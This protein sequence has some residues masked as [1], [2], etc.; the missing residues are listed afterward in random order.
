MST[1]AKRS[2]TPTATPTLVSLSVELPPF[3]SPDDE[4]RGPGPVRLGPAL[5]GQP[6]RTDR[7]GLLRVGQ[8]GPAQDGP[9]RTRR[10]QR[11]THA[12]GLPGLLR[13]AEGRE[14]VADVE[15]VVV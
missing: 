3:R 5:P 13:H 15:A 10:S 1:R 9:G 14:C 8:V 4:R 6:G 7:A 12:T 2:A 11:C